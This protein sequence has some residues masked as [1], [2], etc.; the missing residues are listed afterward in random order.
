M[1]DRPRSA[2]GGELLGA[3]RRAERRLTN[4]TRHRLRSGEERTGV[5]RRC[6][7]HR[8]T[9][10]R[11]RLRRREPQHTRARRDAGSVGAE[12][13]AHGRGRPSVDMK[14][15]Y[16][17]QF[18]GWGPRARGSSGRR[19]FASH[20][21]CRLCLSLRRGVFGAVPRRSHAGR[22]RDVCL[23]GSRPHH[24]VARRAGARGFG[25]GSVE[26]KVISRKIQCH[27]PQQEKC[28]EQNHE[29]DE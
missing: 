6:G 12:R 26:E 9:L 19:R 10:S 4:A 27:V 22:S 7:R 29:K 1:A 11:R 2:V 23:H 5:L 25:L 17:M 8:R 18:C 16:A 3:R 28:G 21:W 24:R 20:S 14:R 13:A 15:N